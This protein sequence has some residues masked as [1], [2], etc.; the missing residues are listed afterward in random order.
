MQRP[1]RRKHNGDFE[2]VLGSARR[3]E[4]AVHPKR[5]TARQQKQNGFYNE[6]KLFDDLGLPPIEESDSD[7]EETAYDRVTIDIN[8]HH[9]PEN[10]LTISGIKIH[11]LQANF[12][13]EISKRVY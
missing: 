12:R 10:V 2:F 1:K 8:N 9:Y 13:L 4:N 7:E 11:L 6:N 5:S 3:P